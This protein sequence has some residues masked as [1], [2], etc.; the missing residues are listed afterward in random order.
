MTIKVGKL[1]PDDCE[2][3]T[4]KDIIETVIMPDLNK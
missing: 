1:N 3:K 2:N 4:I